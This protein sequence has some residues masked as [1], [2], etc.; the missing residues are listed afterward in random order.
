MNLKNLL[1]ILMTG[2]FAFSFSACGDDSTEPSPSSNSNTDLLTSSAWIMTA[3]KIEPPIVI[4]GIEFND[5]Y[6]DMEDCDK[7]D[8]LIFNTDFSGSE[9]EGATKCDPADPQ[10][11]A[12]TWAWASNETQI[13][14]DSTTFDVVSLTT[15]ELK[16]ESVIDGEEFGDTTG[17]VIKL[18]ASFKH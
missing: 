6:A 12:F 4:F 11:E 13:V 18:T 10:S 9:D 14:Y 16:L 8:E 1:V 7:D 2:I 15:T 3:G 17:T 5:I